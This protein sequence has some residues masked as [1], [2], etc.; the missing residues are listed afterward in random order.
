MEQTILDGLQN[1]QLAKEDE[2]SIQISA[3]SRANLLEECHL[4]LFG[5][6]LSNRQQNQH[7]LK[8]TLRSAWKMGSNLRIVEVGN[9]IL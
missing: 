5:K 4:S 1:L 3:H 6:L 2:E 9:D 8:S 7:A